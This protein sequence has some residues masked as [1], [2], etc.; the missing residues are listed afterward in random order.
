MRLASPKLMEP[1]PNDVRWEFAVRGRL[2]WERGVMREPGYLDFDVL[3]ERG[4]GE[5]GY[6]RMW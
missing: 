6:R 2:W 1:C 3:V 4:S 5:H